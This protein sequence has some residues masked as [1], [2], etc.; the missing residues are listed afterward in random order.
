MLGAQPIREKDKGRDERKQCS[1]QGQG[2]M[3]QGRRLLLSSRRSRTKG[4]LNRGNSM[5]KIMAVCTCFGVW[6]IGGGLGWLRHR[7]SLEE[8]RK[9]TAQ[10]SGSMK[11]STCTSFLLCGSGPA[12]QEALFAHRLTQGVIYLDHSQGTWQRSQEVGQGARGLQLV[13]GSLVT[14]LPRAPSVA[15]PSFR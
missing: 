4:I 6:G 3:S 10:A 2:K 5:C 13:K 9:E 1:L 14:A 15:Q 7:V 11:L 8:Q 12:L